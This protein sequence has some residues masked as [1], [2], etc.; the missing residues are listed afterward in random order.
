MT[1]AN[2]TPTQRYVFCQRCGP[3]EHPHKRCPDA[4]INREVMVREADHI[5]ERDALVAALE[6][7]LAVKA[8]SN[9]REGCDT[10]RFDTAWKQAR[11][12]FNAAKAAP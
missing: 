3:V 10:K 6:E 4:G 1:A 11:A 2:H 9:T 12:A 8:L 5:R 7:L